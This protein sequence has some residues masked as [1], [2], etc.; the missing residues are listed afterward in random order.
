MVR[1]QI[2]IAC[3]REVNRL[4][5]GRK[6]K[7]LF[8]ALILAFA[9]GCTTAHVRPYVGKQQ[10]WPTAVGAIVNTSYK[11]PVFTSL[12]PSPYYVLAELRV[13]SPL[14]AQPEEEHLPCL[15][16]KAAQIGA[17]AIVLVDGQLFFSVS[18]GAGNTND[19][20][21]ASGTSTLTAVNKFN[22]DFFKPGVTAVAIKWKG[23]PPPG[24]FRNSVGDVEMEEEKTATPEAAPAPEPPKT[25]PEVKPAAAQPTPPPAATPPSDKPKT[26]VPP[27]DAPKTETAK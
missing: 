5:R 26:E 2:K 8:P 18:Y 7:T 3:S 9:I 6:M 12:P 22:P 4:E 1:T 15:V 19:T 20:K 11:L 25:Q 23:T 10:S 13:E 27:A 14:Y 17:D 21:N 16:N 24:L